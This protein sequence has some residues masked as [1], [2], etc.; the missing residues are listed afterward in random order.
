MRSRRT[1]KEK[2]PA[3]ETRK[4]REERLFVNNG[5][6]LLEE[7]ITSC[8]GKSNP[9]R[10]F[11]KH[12]LQRATNNY[13]LQQIF[14]EEALFNLYKGTIED[15]SVL[16]KKY[17]EDAQNIKWSI[18]EIVVAS[19]MNNHKNM[20]KLLGYCLETDIPTPVFEFAGN[21]DLSSHVL[22]EG[23]NP[24]SRTHPLLP[25]ASRLKI[26]ISAADAVT[27]LH[28][29]TARPIIHRNI[30]SRNILLDH[31]FVTKLADFGVSISIPAGKEHVEDEVRG[32]IGYIAPES[33]TTGRFT[34]KSDV[35]S[36]GM[37][38]FE[39]LTGERTLEFSRLDDLRAVAESKRVGEIVTPAILQEGGVELLQLQQVLELSVKCSSELEW[40][41]PIMMDVAKQLRQ[42]Q[43]SVYPQ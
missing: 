7:L 37:I 10:H 35:F 6:R 38:L 9:F 16:I 24:S 22:I 42:I 26:A 20:L 39:L 32:T 36:F 17:H 11:S 3:S 13:D 30:K 25:W 19:Q 29:A 27:Y 1:G 40:R 12:Q 33:I 4:S 41:R 31:N 34:E 8:D 18:N 5:G 15:R 21:G 43:R 14:H 23:N 2:E 28:T